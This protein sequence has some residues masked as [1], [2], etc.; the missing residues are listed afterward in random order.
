VRHIVRGAA[1]VLVPGVLLGSIV[2]LVVGQLLGAMLFGVRPF[3]AVTFTAVLAVLVVTAA[4]AV[5]GPAFRAT[6][7][8]PVGALR[9]E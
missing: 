5:A 3:D 8:D 2:A 6:H 7:I 4:A 1:R 9:S